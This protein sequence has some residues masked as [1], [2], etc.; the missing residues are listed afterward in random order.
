MAEVIHPRKRKMKKDVWNTNGV[1]EERTEDILVCPESLRD[2]QQDYVG[3]EVSSKS[4]RIGTLARNFDSYRSGQWCYF[5]ATTFRKWKTFI[6]HA[7]FI[8]ECILTLVPC[9][10]PSRTCTAPGLWG[11]QAGI[12]QTPPILVTVYLELYPLAGGCGPS[13]PKPP[14][15]WTVSSPL[16]LG[17]LTGPRTTTPTDWHWLWHS[18]PSPI[19]KFLYIFKYLLI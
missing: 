15:T 7:F 13:G 4:L 16:Q 18:Y 2:Q 6:N 9:N 10:H 19:C 3:T 17:S 8:L 11:G 1:R 5:C 12:W 14:A